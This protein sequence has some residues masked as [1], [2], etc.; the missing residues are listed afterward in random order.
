MNFAIELPAECS[1]SRGEWPC[2]LRPIAHICSDRVVVEILSELSFGENVLR[3]LINPGARF[4]LRSGC[5]LQNPFLMLGLNG[6]DL[7]QVLPVGLIYGLGH[8]VLIFLH[9]QIK[10]ALLL[11]L[12]HSRLD[13]CSIE[14]LLLLGDRE[15]PGRGG[16]MER[17]ER[18]LERDKRSLER[19]R[20][21]SG[22]AEKLGAESLLGEVARF[23]H[24]FKR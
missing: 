14:E 6:F 16:D 3:H 11:F 4:F 19:R 18:L 10:S 21:G 5:F 9:F 13:D 7:R 24:K 8:L 15:W 20:R 23:L 22:A 2:R 12:D 1:S 17:A